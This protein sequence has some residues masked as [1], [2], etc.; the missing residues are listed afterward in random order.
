MFLTAIVRRPR[1]DRDSMGGVRPRKKIEVKRIFPGV[2][3]RM[4]VKKNYLERRVVKEANKR[5]RGIH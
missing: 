5:G 2:N 1:A 4:D 3:A